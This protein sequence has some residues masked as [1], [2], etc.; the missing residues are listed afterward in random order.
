VP[1]QEPFRTLLLNAGST[2]RDPWWWQ[3]IDHPGPDCE[4]EHQTVIVENGRPRL[5]SAEPFLFLWRVAAIVFAGRRRYRYVYTFECGWP[6]LAVSIVQSLTFTRRPRHVILQFIMREKRPT[7][8]SRLKYLFMRWCFSSV[9][10]CVCSSRAEA[11]YYER[12]FGWPASK[13][14]F[15]PLNTD[16]RFLEE[17]TAEGDYVIAAGRT[18]RDYRTLTEAFRSLDTRL[19]IVAG[20]SCS[21]LDRLTPNITLKTDVPAGELGELMAKSLAV[22][23]PLEER[24][25]SIGQTVLLQAMALGKPVIVT[26]VNGTEDYVEH[27]KTGILVPPGDPAAFRE[28]VR[29]ITSDAALRERLG[30][31][32]RERVLSTHLPRH[33]ARAVASTN[34]L[35]GRFRDDRLATKAARA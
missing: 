31:A 34:R 19:L 5:W 21:G 13:L 35:G 8:P 17:P 24:D 18:F 14:A 2:H 30:R 28:A 29:L 4:L 1:D 12:T 6:S 23:L 32:G 25:I 11:R 27:M 33:Y 7:W 10:L 26:R 3:D 16:P 20:R 15:I 22:A 9:H